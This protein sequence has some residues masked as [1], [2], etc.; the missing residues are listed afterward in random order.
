ME[1]TLT[2]WPDAKVRHLVYED[3]DFAVYLDP[4]LD[5]EWRTTD[6]HDDREGIDEEKHHQI[7][8]RA[9]SLECIPNHHHSESI[10][11]NFKRM[12]AEGLARSLSCDYDNATTM[13]DNAEA[14]I[15]DRN[16]ETAR[17]WQLTTA[18]CAGLILGALGAIFWLAR[19]YFIPAWGNTA[20]FVILSFSAGSVGAMLSS[21]F[22]MGRLDITSE[23][24][25]RLHI[26]E[27]LSRVIG[28]AVSGSAM[29]LLVYLGIVA[30]VFKG[31]M[32]THAAMLTSAILAGASER[33]MP[34][35]VSHFEKQQF[36]LAKAGKKK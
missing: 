26:L 32:L 1:E 4:V 21:I 34:S 28:G 16:V 10:R 30:P 27:A 36:D 20:F 24:E 2:K 29:A 31:A 15:R 33:W 11:L 14:Y 18:L 7:V 22:R 5:V 23:A 8:D 25:R 17:F 13:L 12:V 35:L 3:E 19:S 9:A 6:E